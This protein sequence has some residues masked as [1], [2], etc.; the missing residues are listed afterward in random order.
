MANDLKK[1]RWQAEKV[2]VNEISLFK[3]WRYCMVARV[4]AYSFLHSVMF[5]LVFADW[6][7]RTNALL[8]DSLA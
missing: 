1:G 4:D 3:I 7:R 5:S 2:S 8:R 6:A